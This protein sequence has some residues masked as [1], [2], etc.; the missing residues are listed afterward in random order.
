MSE[1][2]VTLEL[3][4]LTEVGLDYGIQLAS[5]VKETFHPA[6][7]TETANGERTLDQIF[8]GLAGNE[9][10]N[11]P[12]GAA[13]S[14]LGE[15]AD[16]VRAAVVLDGYTHINDAREDAILVRVGERGMDHSHEFAQRYA[17]SGLRKKFQTVGN[18]GYMGESAP[19]FP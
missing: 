18:V 16:V 3:W 1:L 2:P 7:V 11:D 19:I 6:L 13:V 10:G 9:A 8:L 5:D 17:R 4:G 14:I 12:L 15:K